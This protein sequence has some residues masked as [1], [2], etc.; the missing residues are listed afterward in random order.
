MVGRELTSGGAELTSERTGL[1]RVESLGNAGDG[2]QMSSFTYN[3]LQSERLVRRWVEKWSSPNG[4]S[5]KEVPIQIH[6]DCKDEDEPFRRLH[7][8]QIVSWTP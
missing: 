5:F 6:A 3:F 8:L 2:G 1:S 7:L 4:D